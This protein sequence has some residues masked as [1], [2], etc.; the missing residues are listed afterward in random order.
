VN[1][2]PSSPIQ[3]YPADHRYAA[4]LT[5]GVPLLIRSIRSGDT[6]AL[7]RFHAT[8]SEETVRSRYFHYVG[9]HAR[10]AA[11]RLARICRP[12]T[13]VEAVLVAIVFPDDAQREQIVGV[14]RLE[15]MIN[16]SGEVAFVVSDA[17]QKQ[18]IGGALM[19]QLLLLA[20]R[21]GL[22]NLHAYIL[23]DN[24]PMQR[25]CAHAGFDVAFSKS[26]GTMK[27]HLLLQ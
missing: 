17:W 24:V 12:D 25:L 18:G 23:P 4:T 15:E 11:A 21:K 13:E 20:R 5:T 8:L 1:S 6:A 19:S 22:I 16:R 27:A 7:A 9:L 2:V 3:R 26:S 14:G 10:I